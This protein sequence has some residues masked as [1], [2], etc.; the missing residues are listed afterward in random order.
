MIMK[1]KMGLMDKKRE[2]V[3]ATSSST[4]AMVEMGSKNWGE[5]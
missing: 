4:A 5:G 1:I 2:E 3:K